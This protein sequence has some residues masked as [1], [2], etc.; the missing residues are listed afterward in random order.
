MVSIGEIFSLILQR[1]AAG[2][3]HKLTF[4]SVL[5]I[6]KF[7]FSLLSPGIYSQHNVVMENESDSKIERFYCV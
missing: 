3:W 6:E 2:N 4:L 1:K 5:Y 7:N